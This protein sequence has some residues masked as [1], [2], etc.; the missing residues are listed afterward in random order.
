MKSE[1]STSTWPDQEARPRRVLRE[2]DQAKDAFHAVMERVT[3]G[4]EDPTWVRLRNP[5][6]GGTCRVAGRREPLRRAARE[7]C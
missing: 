2:A 6:G 3:V 7:E 4:G 5:G 1:T